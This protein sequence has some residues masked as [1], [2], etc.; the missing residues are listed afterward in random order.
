MQKIFHFH[1]E[2]LSRFALKEFCNPLSFDWIPF[3]LKDTFILMLNTEHYPKSITNPSAVSYSGHIE[4]KWH[5]RDWKVRENKS[6]KSMRNELK[7][8]EMNWIEHCCQLFILLFVWFINHF[9][10][11]L[12]VWRILE[13]RK[14]LIHELIS[15]CWSYR[16]ISFWIL[17][18]SGGNLEIFGVLI[19][20]KNNQG[21]ETDRA[22]LHF[23]VF[24]SVPRH[25]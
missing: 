1:A 6:I 13:R 3:S 20:K 17:I 23:A 11:H 22:L 2:I 14:K 18:F 12:A 16:K 21:P 10:K 19:F 5:Y 4:I 7:I 25:K 24:V 9:V 15:F 8:L